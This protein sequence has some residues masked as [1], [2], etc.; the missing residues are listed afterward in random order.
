M[1]IE[2]LTAT[3]LELETALIEAAAVTEYIALRNVA[4]THK[5]R[6]ARNRILDALDRLVDA[7]KLVNA[8]DYIVR[9]PRFSWCLPQDKYMIDF[10]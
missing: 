2:T 5:A 9:A 3:D 8:R 7:G 4:Q 10:T 6:T 1:E